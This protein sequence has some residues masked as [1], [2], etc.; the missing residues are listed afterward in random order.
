MV[1]FHIK[2]KIISFLLET[3]EGQ[4]LRAGTRRDARDATVL[5]SFLPGCHNT[6]SP[7]GLASAWS[8]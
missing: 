8:S 4:P 6:P 2:I 1:R 7:P 3:L 5:P